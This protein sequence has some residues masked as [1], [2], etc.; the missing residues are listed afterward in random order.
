MIV[1]L[2]C[3][4]MVIMLIITTP[5]SGLITMIVTQICTVKVIRGNTASIQVTNHQIV[6][7]TSLNT[8][9]GHN[10]A[11]SLNAT[12]GLNSATGLNR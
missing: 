3:T 6:A 2:M 11:R 5:Q 1:T 7:Y 10:T 12:T 8:T 9:T 4:L